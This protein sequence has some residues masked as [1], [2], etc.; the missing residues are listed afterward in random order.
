MTK[1]G[2]I[3]PHDKRIELDGGLN[4]KFERSIILD[5]ESPECQ[6]VIFS[7]GAVETR[8]G[9]T[10]KT[11]SGQVSF[12]FDGLFVR[13]A[14]TGAESMLAAARGSIYEFNTN[15]FVTIGSA[16][17]VFTVGSNVGFAQYENHIFI[18]QNGKTPY[19]Y[20][21]TDFTRH[22]V[23]SAPCALTGSS[24]NVGSLDGDYSWKVTF[25]NS[26]VVQGNVNLTSD[27]LAISNGTASLACLPIAPQS[28]GVDARNLYRTASS[29]TTYLKVATISDNTTT[30]YEDTVADASLGTAAPTDNGLP[31]NYEIII[32]YR[33]RLFVNDPSNPNYVWYSNLGDPYT[34][35]STSFF[36][37]GDNTTD[38]VKAFGIIQNTLVVFGEESIQ[39]VYMP[40]TTASNWSFIAGEK[41][42]GCKSPRGIIN[43]RGV[44]LFPAVQ[45]DKFIGFAALSGAGIEPSST[46][47]TVLNAGSE[48][49]SDRIEPSMFLVQEAYLQ[50]ISA[51]VY[52]NKAY[53]TATYGAG[54]E[55]NNRIWV[56][57]FSI[58]NLSRK[59]QFT[60][61]PWVNMN[62]EQFTILDGDLI[63][64]SSSQSGHVYKMND[65][66]YNDDDAAIDSYIW[67]KEFGGGPGDEH[68]HKDFRELYV[69]TEQSG[70][71]NLN[72]NVR[73]DSDSG[74]GTA[75]TADLTPPSGG[76]WGDDWDVMKWGGGAAQTEEIVG[77]TQAG[78][79]IQYRFRTSTANQY[80]KVHAIGFKYNRK[81][82]R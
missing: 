82:L 10:K 71:W 50:N 77:L 56:F 13:K 28:W 73:L 4:N 2:V 27:T 14:N 22:G 68:Y 79:R 3:Y 52:K 34:F 69:L 76:V 30:T 31:P 49:Q 81:G 64:A 32:Y 24:K 21:G 19:K 59:Q 54:E 63:Y 12:P 29:G 37:M 20:N 7:N 44:L 70:S 74:D 17:S 47:L 16:Q 80:F 23:Y 26:Q 6:N 57:D 43:F 38:V 39:Y 78:K 72:I 46:F 1:R 5:N 9:T 48:L 61:V 51:M 40:D 36:K 11:T 8:E 53:Y 55:L 65:G 60:W 67:T 75:L 58:S 25:V 15:T 35:G 42:F 33:D 18:G 45:N 62:A 41:N 66:T